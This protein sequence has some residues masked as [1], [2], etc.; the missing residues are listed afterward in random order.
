MYLPLNRIKSLVLL[1]CSLED[2]YLK[3]ILHGQLVSGTLLAFPMTPS[4]ELKAAN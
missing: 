4:F 3:P 2:H 1:G